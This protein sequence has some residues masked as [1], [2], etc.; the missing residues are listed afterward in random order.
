[1]RTARRSLRF[2]HILLTG[3]LLCVMF[4]LSACGGDSHIQQQSNDAKSQLDQQIQL[5]QKNGVPLT[6]LQ[7]LLQAEQKT[8]SNN[9]PG[10][11]FDDA[12]LN[13]YYKNQ[14][15]AYQQLLDKLQ[16]VVAIFTGQVKGQAQQDLNTFQ[17]AL[18][19]E[20]SANL[21]DVQAFSQRYTTDSSH[22]QK[23]TIPDEFIAISKDAVDAATALS[24][25]TAANQQ[26]TIFQATIN[27]MQQAGLTVKALQTDYNSDLKT[28]NTATDSKSFQQ[29][30]T[31]INAQYQIAMV[32]TI[33]ALPYVGSA[34]L[35]ELQSKIDE[36]KNDGMDTSIYDQ[37]YS[38]YKKSIAQATTIA[39][40][41]TIA[42]Q[43][44]AD[45]T[46][47]ATDIAIGQAQNRV[48][49]LNNQ[50]LAWGNAH[51]YHDSYDGNDYILD[52]GYTNAGIGAWLQ[53]ELN[54][55]GNS[56]ATLTDINNEIFNFQM[57]REDYSDTTPYTQVHNTDLEMMQHYPNLQHG[58]VAIVSLV[59]QVMR[60]YDNGNLVKAFQVTTG[61]VE[62]PSLPGMWS[63]LLRELPTTFT[64]SE[65]YG[66][67]YWYPPTPINYAMEYHAN[68][69]FLHDAW[70][71]D[72]FGQGTQY[73]HYDTGG[74]E[75]FAG[76]GSHGCVNMAEN[77]AKWLYQNSDYTLQVAI[78]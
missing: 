9:A 53:T 15:K 40:Y 25:L 7:P 48:T 52:S 37:H 60:V 10:N 49:E 44:D 46:S 58:M 78:Y 26:L 56:Q 18:N 47:M 22:L 33:Q 76:N 2:A 65:P 59:E 64:S 16:T 14:A 54:T 3:T 21:G 39:Q 51:L 71:R 41:L 1:M 6:A 74:D 11:I 5:A 69:Y 4:L 42:Q 19:Q 45:I 30:Q 50:A 67:A 38:T 57:L 35:Q 73:P 61:R 12:S 17:Q 63:T 24:D 75:L 68:G 55:D 32:S 23:A 27:Q 34:K 20:K 36:L 13:T 66:S 77:D 62:L 8:A 28:V 43:I 31:L 70:W 29:L 72:N